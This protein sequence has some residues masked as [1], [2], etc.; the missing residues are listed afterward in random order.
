MP[1]YLTNLAGLSFRPAESKDVVKMLR[2]GMQLDLEREPN[3]PWDANAIQVFAL[4]RAD[5]TIPLE[6]EDLGHGEPEGYAERH[7]IGYVEKLVNAPLARD[8]DEGLTFI[9]H[10]EKT[11]DDYDQPIKSSMWSKPLIAI[12]TRPR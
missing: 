6:I 5:T 7:F 11:Y 10:V 9:C 3:N 8:M 2:P 12:E 4:V 1:K